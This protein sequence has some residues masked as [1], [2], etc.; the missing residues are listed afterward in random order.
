MQLRFVAPFQN[1]SS[2]R[3]QRFIG[4]QIQH[5]I[6]GPQNHLRDGHAYHGRRFATAAQLQ[7][8]AISL[9]HPP[10]QALK[11]EDFE[12][13]QLFAQQQAI[14]RNRRPIQDRP[15]FL[16]AEHGLQIGQGRLDGFQGGVRIENVN[17]GQLLPAQLEQ[18]RGDG[19][20][21]RFRLQR[22]HQHGRSL[23]LH[24]FSLADKAIMTGLNIG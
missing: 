14:R 4:R 16:I 6:A 2:T 5:L 15:M 8:Y 22:S 1:I 13:Q 21:L 10:F 11:Q 19:D 23:R 9:L 18:L 24:R 7:K 12:Q 3:S 17:S 20:G